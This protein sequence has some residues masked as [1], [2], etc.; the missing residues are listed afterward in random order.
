MPF[1]LLSHC[2]SRDGSLPSSKGEK[3]AAA[4]TLKYVGKP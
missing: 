1:W 4:F 2:E 3:M